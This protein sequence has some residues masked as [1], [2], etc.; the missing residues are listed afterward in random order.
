MWLNSFNI[1]KIKNNFLKIL[2]FLIFGIPQF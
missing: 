1:M 2:D